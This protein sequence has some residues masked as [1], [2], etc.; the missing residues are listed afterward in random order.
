MY[1][2]VNIDENEIFFENNIQKY[3]LP[4]YNIS[5]AV[6]EGIKY[7]DTDKQRAVYRVT[8]PNGQYCLKK[9][10]YG[11]SE[12]LFTYSAI[13]WWYR[14]GIN[15]PQLLPTY[16]YE[17]FVEVNNMLFILTPWVS[18]S[19][20]NYDI[21]DNFIKS[22]KN[23]GKMHGCSKDFEPI[24]GSLFKVQENTIYSSINKHF[25]CLLEYSNLAFKFKDKF[26]KIFLKN[27]TDILDI[28]QLSSTVASNINKDNLTKALCHFDYVNK[29]ILLDD[30]DDIWVIDFDNC[31]YG[32]TAH[33]ISYSL[34]RYLRRNNTCWNLDNTILWLNNYCKY[35]DLT[36]DDYKYIFA[37]VVFPQKVWRI[38]RDYYK[39]IYKC[40]KTSFCFLLENALSNIHKQIEFVYNF[41][42]Y[43][44]DKFFTRIN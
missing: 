43:I 6:V 25:L 16:T 11:P 7:K 44:E 10:F 2:K 37:S 5:S 18:G 3:I 17:R 24:S 26:S 20:C 33:E 39:N 23:L 29:N 4:F 32:Y 19:K 12:L 27:F 34:R 14:N 41:Q 30:D 22:G 31:K 8:S 28:S 21:L 40:N 13:E 35:C 1:N 36:L 15:V 42:E 38:S 9:V